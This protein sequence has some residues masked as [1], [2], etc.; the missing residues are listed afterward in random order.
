[1]K[2]NRETPAISKRAEKL[3]S[4]IKRGEF[5]R[6]YDSRVPKAMRELEDAGLVSVTGRVVVIEACYV[7]ATGYRPYKHESFKA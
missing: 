5:Y 6:A 1:M 7:P 4:R 2:N 3:L